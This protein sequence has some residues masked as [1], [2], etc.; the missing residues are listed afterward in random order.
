VVFPAEASGKEAMM[1]VLSPI[2]I[3]LLGHSVGE[4][5]VCETPGGKTTLGIRALLFQPESI[6]QY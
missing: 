4:T 2:G 5:V 6:G 1:S 3:A